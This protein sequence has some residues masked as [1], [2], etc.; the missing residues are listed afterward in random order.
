MMKRPGD[1]EDPVR[2]AFADMRRIFIGVAGFSLFTSMLMLTG[3]LYMLQVYDRVLASSSVH[4]LVALTVLI[5]VLYAGF[6]VL[7]WVRNGILSRAGSRFEDI[8]GDRTLI[9]T[10]KGRLEDPGRGSDKPIRDLRLLRRFLGSPAVTAMF[11][12]PF[13]VMFL[14]IIFL[15]HWGYGLLALSGGI[16][17]VGIAFLN[18][19]ISKK[20][21]HDAERFEA[22]AQARIM[23][24][25]QNAEIIEALGLGE[26]VR[27]KWRD[28]FDRSDAALVSSSSLLGRF[29]S[30]TKAIRLF[31]QS[32]V[33]GLGAYLS[34][35]GISTP[36]EMIAA[37]ILTG[38]AIGPLEQLVGQWRSVSSARAA[39]GTLSATLIGKAA[40]QETMELPPIRGAVQFEGVSAGPPGASKPFLQQLNFQ[41]EAG[42]IVGVI[43]PSA[44][45]KS[46]LV[47][48]MVGIWKAQI[49]TVRLDG[50]DISTWPRELL[51]P[52]LGYLPQQ[53]DLFSGRIHE[54]ISR[55]DPEATSEAVIAAAQ[56]AGCHDM[57]QRLPDGYDTEIGMRGAYLSAGQRQRI[58]L[59]RALYGEP[60]IIILDEPN[61]N[62]D[63]VG[64]VALQKAIAGLKARQAT[65]IMI[66]HRPK[67]IGQCNKLLMLD[68]GRMRAFGPRDEVLAEVA[69]ANVRQRASQ[70][71]GK[72][73]SLPKG[74]ND[75]G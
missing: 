13:S 51:G 65:V 7:D 60:T 8:L 24:V 22:Q 2:D 52:Q 12:A 75:G 23:E 57:I 69:P 53:V 40:A 71:G 26:R 38:R 20:T 17:L 74:G 32:S 3:P 5:L 19:N 41:I 33:L 1:Q 68:N 11:D 73:V 43:G 10:I 70:Q 42:D 44:A 34:I 59:A 61:S 6:A 72:I 4:T 29:S 30:G 62:L 66:A 49:G 31:L 54:N 28:E 39:W 36:G 64:E 18:Q 21:V 37:S 35:V 67:S 9:A 46:S 14:L 15:I 25:S 63:S 55:F 58:G 45:G 50:S 56:A 48:L 47:R 16:V 27:R